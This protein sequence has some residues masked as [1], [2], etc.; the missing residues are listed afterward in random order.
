[1]L[2]KTRKSAR[3]QALTHEKTVPVWSEWERCGLGCFCIRV[4]MRKV[5]YQNVQGRA[6]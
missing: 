6:K 3:F 4:P 2:Y 1:M 5:G